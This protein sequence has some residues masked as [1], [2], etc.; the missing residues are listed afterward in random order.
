M[1]NKM[2]ESTLVN[3]V[4]NK[5]GFTSVEPSFLIRIQGIMKKLKLTNGLIALVDDDIYEKVKDFTWNTDGRG[6]V[7]SSMAAKGTAK[8]GVRRKP[9]ALHHVVSPPKEGS[10]VDHKDRNKLDNRREKLRYV[11]HSVNALNGSVRSTSKTGVKGV[12]AWWRDGGW[13]AY[14][15]VNGKQI[16]LGYFKKFEDAVK[17]RQDFNDSMD[18]T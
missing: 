7:K 5:G 16:H 14:A 15:V 2:M 9:I 10:E 18:V 1:Y 4:F 3:I 17:A 11:T 13:R 8:W 6:Y 12:C